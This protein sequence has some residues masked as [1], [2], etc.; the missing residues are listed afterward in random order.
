MGILIYLYWLI[1]LNA[2]AL[3]NSRL[4][5]ISLKPSAKDYD[6]ELDGPEMDGLHIE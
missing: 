4:C 2:E 3:V 5:I 6:I 1:F